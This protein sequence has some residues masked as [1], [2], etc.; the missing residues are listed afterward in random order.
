MDYTSAM[1]PKQLEEA[2]LSREIAPIIAIHVA[3]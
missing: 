3:A 1:A 2:A